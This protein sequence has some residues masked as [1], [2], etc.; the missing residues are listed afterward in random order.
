MLP[1]DSEQDPGPDPGAPAD[2]LVTRR[3]ALH[4]ALA[5][6]ALMTIAA[7]TAPTGGA[8]PAAGSAAGS[9]AGKHV[10][11]GPAPGRDDEIAAFLIEWQR[12]TTAAVE[13]GST[14]DDG[15][16]HALLAD[17]ARLDPAAFPKRTK[18]AF[19]DGQFTSGPILASPTFLVLEFELVPG[20]PIQAHN[21]VGFSFVSVGVEGEATVRHYEPDGR[22]PDPGSE[23]DVPFALREVQRTVL[24]RGRSSS[25][26]RTRAN[27][28]EFVAGPEGARFLDFGVHYTSPNGGYESFSKLAIDA[29]PTDAARGIHTARWIGNPKG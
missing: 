21:H 11:T 3:A 12:R 9:A 24:T 2:V 28:H 22:A 15:H 23:L 19:T 5:L 27:I 16:L 8:A 26:T 4:G 18:D 20:A 25:L 7:C 13:A 29:E 1:H 17:L 6:P 14:D 10:A